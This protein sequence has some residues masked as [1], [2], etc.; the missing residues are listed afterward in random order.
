M[1]FVY[2]YM[3]KQNMLVYYLLFHLLYMNII[4]FLNVGYSSFNNS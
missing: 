4:I 3:C 2:F 1:Q